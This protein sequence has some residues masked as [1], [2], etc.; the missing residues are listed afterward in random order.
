MYTSQVIAYAQRFCLATVF[1]AS[2]VSFL[3]MLSKIVLENSTM[4]W[5]IKLYKVSYCI[6]MIY[7]MRLKPENLANVYGL[8]TYIFFFPNFNRVHSHLSEVQTLPLSRSASQTIVF[9]QFTYLQQ[10][11]SLLSTEV[12]LFFKASKTPVLPWF[13]VKDREKLRQAFCGCQRMSFL[14][15]ITQH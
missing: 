2:Y 15:L 1:R 14:L 4:L 13:N 6:N 11:H 7:K 9:W 10:M 8:G 12:L 3:F 5:Y